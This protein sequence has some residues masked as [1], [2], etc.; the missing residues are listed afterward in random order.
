MEMELEEKPAQATR[1]KH[2]EITGNE[3]RGHGHKTTKKKTC[4]QG[5]GKREKETS[6]RKRRCAYQPT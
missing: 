5:N 2:K 4:G 1:T 3:T 6:E